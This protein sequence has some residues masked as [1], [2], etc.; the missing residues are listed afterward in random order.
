MKEYIFD[1]SKIKLMRNSLHD[2]LKL[3]YSKPIQIKSTKGSKVISEDGIEYLDCYNNVFV[4]GHANE[5]I[6]NI[7]K[8]QILTSLLNTRYYHK[9]VEEYAET[10]LSTFP[11]PLKSGKVFFVNSG[12]EAN[13]LAIRL[14]LSHVPGGNIITLKNSYHGTTSVCDSIS[15]LD[16]YTSDGNRTSNNNVVVVDH[17]NLNCEFDEHLKVSAIIAEPIQG[18][19]GHSVVPL[20]KLFNK[21][22]KTSNEVSRTTSLVNPVCIVDEVQT[23]FGRTGEMWGF[24]WS[25]GCNPDIVTLGKPMGNGVPI[26]AVVCTKEVASSFKGEYFNTY[27]GNPL[28]CAIGLYVLRTIVDEKL[29]CKALLIEDLFKD[30]LRGLK[31]IKEVRGYGYFIGIIFED[32]DVLTTHTSTRSSS[33]TPAQFV[34]EVL[35]QDYHILTRA[36]GD[37]LRLKGPLTT[38]FQDLKRVISAIKDILNKEFHLQ[39]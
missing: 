11:E 29:Y 26:G 28:S 13:D 30:E 36:Y 21:F 33:Q 18:C 27:G 39:I 6:A 34:C 8:E 38:S 20:K 7:A 14:A 4:L 10:L 31:G 35:K 17:K 5:Q 19:G 15:D 37:V 25:D 9:I 22:R 32:L 3:H 2:S 1:F 12:S 16:H 23:G 24:E